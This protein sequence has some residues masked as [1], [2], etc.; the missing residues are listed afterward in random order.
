[1]RIKVKL[2]IRRPL[3]R[4][5]LL[6]KQ[7]K[8]TLVTFAYER[9]PT[10]CFI[11][12][13]IGHIDRF[14]ELR[15]RI[16]EAQIVKLWDKSL[17]APPRRRNVEPTSKW[18]VPSPREQ[19]SAGEQLGRTPLAVIESQKPANLKALSINLRASLEN[20]HTELT[21]EPKVTEE[22]KQAIE[23]TEDRK[24]RRGNSESEMEIDKENVD[25]AL[26]HGCHV[27]KN[28]VLAGSG[29]ETCP[30]Q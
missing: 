2:D 17:K 21:Y 19:L 25:S 14:C 27:P 5:K 18:L 13:R 7:N 29:T 9:L 3:K 10:F 8:E 20:R 11:C 12:G 22:E 30:P 15:F 26:L 23:I 1:M 28:M 24:R 6:R 16:P 4:E